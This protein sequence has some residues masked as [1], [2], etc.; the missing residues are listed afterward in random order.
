MT[1]AF[2]EK[3]KSAAE[4]K[5]DLEGADK[6]QEKRGVWD[7]GYG[8]G[9]DYGHGHGHGHGWEEDHHVHHH[10]EKTIIDV[11]K[12]PV[13]YPVEKHVPVPVHKT[14]HYPVKVH[15]PHHVPGLN[16]FFSLI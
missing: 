12:I 1:T 14:V 8:F 9:G 3:E 11:K 5:S 4:E 6:K 16:Y 2:C 10:H 13:H 7:E 15:V